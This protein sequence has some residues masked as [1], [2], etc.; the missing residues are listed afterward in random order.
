MDT[1]RRREEED[2]KASHAVRNWKRDRQETDR[3]KQTERL[4]M[5]S[6]VSSSNRASSTTSRGQNTLLGGDRK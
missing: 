6:V 1:E 3:E 2:E 4:T 5:D